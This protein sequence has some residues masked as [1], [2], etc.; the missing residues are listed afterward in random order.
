MNVA[1]FLLRDGNKVGA[2]VS[3]EGLEIFTYQDPK[4]QEIHALATVKA[5]RE[6]LKQV[7]SK[8]LPLYVRMEHALAKTVGRG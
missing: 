5:E 3:P 1:R 6:F 4:G 7:P 2:A 8:L